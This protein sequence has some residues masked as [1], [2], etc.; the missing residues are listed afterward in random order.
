[1]AQEYTALGRFAEALGSADLCVREASAGAA[2]VQRE[3]VLGECRSMV[4]SLQ[5]RVGR[6]VVRVPTPP[7]AELRITVGGRPLPQVVWDA[8]F[9]VTPGSI[10]VEA[11]SPSTAPVQ[12]VV[13]V[14]AAQTVEVSLTFSPA[15]APEAHAAVA[16]PTTPA[17]PA[18]ASPAPLPTAPQR[19][20]S[21]PGVAPWIVVALGGAS[22]GVSLTFLVL[23]QVALA[24]ADRIGRC[25]ATGCDPAGRPFHDRAVDDTTVANITLATGIAGVGA[26]VLWYLLARPGRRTATQTAWLVAP[27]QDGVSLGLRGS[28]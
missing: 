17:P 21:G 28:F 6:V 8:P 25:D 7:P 10:Q 26:G 14:A 12:R 5:Q 13:E 15:A 18:P 3:R 20:S 22:L 4:T 16:P 24:D 19:V 9:V 2:I 23:Q 1:M 11:L 27:A